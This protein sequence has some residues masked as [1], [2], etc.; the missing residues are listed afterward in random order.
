MREYAQKLENK[1]RTLDSNPRASKQAPISEILQAYQDRTLGKSVQRQEIDDD[2]LLQLKLNVAQ[3]EEFDEDELIQPQFDNIQREKLDDDELLQPKFESAYA[4]EQ[5]P[6]QQ[7]ERPNNTGLPDNL[8]SGIEN[9]SGYSMD[10]VKVHYNS[11]KPAQLQALAYAQGADIHV[12]S[13][14]EQ[15]LSHEAWHVVQQKQGRVQP[16]MQLQG[17]NVNDNEGL[18]READEMG[19]K[20]LFSSVNQIISLKWNENLNKSQRIIQRCSYEYVLQLFNKKMDDFKTIIDRIPISQI[21]SILIKAK[22]LNIS[23]TFSS[24]W[25]YSTSKIRAILN[26]IN[27]FS[28]RTGYTQIKTIQNLYKR[29]WLN[30]LYGNESITLYPLEGEKPFEEESTKSS[31]KVNR[32]IL[33]LELIDGNLYARCYLALFAPAQQKERHKDITADDGGEITLKNVNLMNLGNPFKALLWCEDYIYNSE[34]TGKAR[35]VVRSFLIPLDRAANLICSQDEEGV[36][37]GTR[38]VDQDRASGQFSNLGN[39]TVYDTGSDGG[40]LKPLA[41]SLVSFF[42]SEAD[43]NA[44]NTKGQRKYFLEDLQEF[45]TGERG[46]V[47][48][49]T[50]KE[51]KESTTLASQHGR[52]DHLAEFIEKYKGIM[53]AYYNSLSDQGFTAAIKSGSVTIKGGNDISRQSVHEKIVSDFFN[54]PMLYTSQMFI[55]ISNV[56]GGD[57]LYHALAGRDLTHQEIVNVRRNVANVRRDRGFHESRLSDSPQLNY[58]SH[59]YAATVLQSPSLRDKIDLKGIHKVSHHKLA[60]IQEKPGVYAGV[61]EIIQWCEAY[62]KSVI[63][64]DMDGTVLR[65]TALGSTRLDTSI[66]E[67][68]YQN[69]I[70]VYNSGSHWQRVTGLNQ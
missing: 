40:I 14:Q 31:H 19:R 65:Y 47:G 17:V 63:V 24:N 46:S 35:P 52:D 21:C 4:V 50:S 33:E 62:R 43:Y 8:K 15:H 20:S 39:N 5:T 3:C 18:E 53:M 23:I 60:S 16:T 27:K 66:Q 64:I 59:I 1:S 12:A 10:D 28:V 57:C 22:E 51:S 2:E 69:E 30:P 25:N 58:N 61:E 49:F 54:S 38:P 56:G 67:I 48:D 34:H 36:K 68:D 11:D 7:E 45:L 13:G 26:E 70:V 55:F 9:L 32:P 6:I 29:I 37:T 42:Y 44:T 41:G